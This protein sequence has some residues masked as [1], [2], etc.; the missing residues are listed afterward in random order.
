MFALSRVV[1]LLPEEMI[2]DSAVSSEH[3]TYKTVKAKFW[4]WL[5]GKSPLT[6]FK[7]FPLRSEA[8]TDCALGENG[9]GERRRRGE[10]RVEPPPPLGPP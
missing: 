7:V 6:P 4:P 2:W 10:E 3:G 1:A 5:S 9:A 8:D